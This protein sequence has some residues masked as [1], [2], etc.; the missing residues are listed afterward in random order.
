MARDYARAFYNS[1][2]WRTV[3]EFV[4]NRDLGLCVRCDNPGTEVHHTT[5]LRPENIND[6]DITLNPARLITLCRECHLAEHQHSK[7]VAR[8]NMIR[9]YKPGTEQYDFDEMGQP[10]PKRNVFILHGAP[11]SGKSTYVAQNKGEY[12]I[13]FDADLVRSALAMATDRVDVPDTLPWVNSIREQVYNIVANRELYFDRVWLIVTMPKRDDRE[14]LAKRLRGDLIHIDT[15]IEECK[16]R[17]RL[18][19]TRKNKLK[20]MGAI[21]WYFDEFT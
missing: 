14:A 21:N 15:G 8:Y 19:D 3:R 1:M 18:D 4:F 10:A 6:P 9:Q 11:G 20:D 17:V 16:T 2:A 12:D 7:L 13:V 5:Y